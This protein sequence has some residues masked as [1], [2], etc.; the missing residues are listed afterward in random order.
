MERLRVNMKFNSCL[1]VEVEGRS[2]GLS[3]MWKDTI[4]CR[5]LNYSRNFINL[6]VKE[7]EEDEWRLT[8]YYGYP[9]RGRRRKAWDLLRELR[10]MSDLPWCIIGDFNDLLAQEDKKGNHPHPNWLCNGFRSAVCDCDLTDIHLEGY[11]FTWTKSRGSPN[12]IEERLDR[13]MANSKWLMNFPNVKLVNL[14]TSHS[15]H[16]PIL[17]Q[18]SPMTR[19]GKSYSFRFEN[20]WLKEEDIGVVVEEGW[21]RERGTDITIKTARCAEKLKWWGKRK[22]MRFKKD[23]LECSEELERLRGCHDPTNSWR[24]KE[25]Q[26]KHARLLI[27]E[28]AYWRQRAKMHWLKEGDLNTKF[29]HMSATSR[30]RAKKIGKLMNDD[31]IAVT[32]QPELCE[33]ALNYFNHLFKSNSTS[34][35]PVLSLIAPKIT[36]EDN[37]SLVRPI[38]KE[39]LKDALFQMNPDKAPGPDGFNPAFYQHFWDLCSNDIFEAAQEWLER[40]YFPSSLNET[41]ICLIPKCETPIS[42][43]DLRPISLCN[44]LYKMISK[45]LANRLRSCLDKCVSEEQ[46]AFIEGRSILDNALIAVE[47]IHA[48][49]RRTRGFKGELALKI[50]ISKA[51]DK[52]DWGFLR[53]MLERLGFSNKWIHWMM[54]CVSSVN[55]SVLV[56]FEKV[57]PIIPGRGLR[58]GDPL[59]PYLFI[60]VTEGLST[61]LKKSLASGELHGVQICRGAPVVSHLLFADDCFLFCRSTVAETE[62]LMRILKTYGEASGQEINLTKSEVFFSRNL[63][64]ADQEDL[65]KIMGVKHVLGTGNYLGLPSM[66]GRKKKHIFAFIKDRIWKRI[67]SWRGRALSRAGKEVMIKSVLQAIPAYVMSVYLLPDAIIKDIERMMNSFWWGGGT[68]NKGIRWMAWDRM[69]IPKGQGGMGFRDLHSFNLAMIAKQGWNIMTKPH[70]LLAKLYKAR[71][72][73]GNGDNIKVMHDPWLRGTNGA[74]LPSPQDQGVHNFHVNDLMFPNAKMWDKEKIES[75]FPIHIANRILEIPLFDMIEEDKL[76]WIDSTNGCY[77]V[78]SGY[79]LMMNVTGKVNVVPQQTDWHRLWSISAPPKAK[80]LLWRISKGCLPTRMRLQEKH[81]PC[82]LLCPVCN[83]HNE[84]DWHVLFGCETSIQARQTAGLV[85]VI[86]SRLQQCTNTSQLIHMICSSEDKTTAGLF[87]MLVWTLWNNRNNR[88]WNETSEPG[89]S[90]GTKAQVL[91]GEWNSV[92][93]LHNNNT[94]TAQQHLQHGASGTEQQQQQYIRWQAPSYGWYKCNVDAGFHQALNK[95]STG[96]CLRDHMGRF[97]M[98]ETTWLEGNCSILEGEATALIQALEVLRQ[99]GI[100]NVIF[101][102]DSKNVVDAVHHLHGGSSEFSLFICHINNI[103]QC[104]PNFMVKFIKR[105]ANMVAHTLARAAISWPRRYQFETLPI[106][107]APLL[108]NEML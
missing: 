81:V 108:N 74:W 39:E 25:V 56:N 52:V 90:L 84:D 21:G 88:V 91:W 57:G 19:N 37:E 63:S 9:E 69:A 18:N 83:Q 92:Q 13:A 36:Q 79:N 60:L 4:S 49:K 100:S 66:I 95:T 47:V 8:C 107:I 7:K 10:D 86:E 23:V 59:S 55:Y 72:S 73:V 89:R 62:Q 42:M 102:T 15:D 68:N 5:V 99:K 71:W 22:R 103:L 97:V 77:S 3:V 17:L 40:G 75:L 76:I 51:Y 35:D 46:S 61:L 87:A 28:E 54:L 6:I 34:H 50:D 30:Q 48:L 20:S 96:W 93:Q 41:N 12:V 33:V 104:N 44:V 14:L 82:P 98:A 16:S 26:E 85:H 105:Q 38:S 2:G 67:N 43:K 31:N 45:L 58:Q 1:S 53:G 70:T 80:H 106:C 101:E 24:F 94:H 29:F 64:I 65:S 11:P 27:Q 32:S 78:K